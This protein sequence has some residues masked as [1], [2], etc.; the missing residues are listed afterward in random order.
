MSFVFRVLQFEVSIVSCV[1]AATAISTRSA[2]KNRNMPR[3]ASHIKWKI[4]V[5]VCVR[6]G[7]RAHVVRMHV[8]MY[9]FVLLLLD[10]YT[11]SSRGFA[12]NN[13]RVVRRRICR[14]AGLHA[15]SRVSHIWVYLPKLS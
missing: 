3:V 11:C 5:C 12:D 2:N 10:H 13:V 6:L 9:I 8:A 7:I 1:S 4:C 14:R 15:Y